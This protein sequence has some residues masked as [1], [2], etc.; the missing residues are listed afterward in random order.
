MSTNPILIDIPAE[1][2]TDRLRLRTPLPGDGPT[3][4]EAVCASHQ[5]LAPWM[6][7]A[8]SL[9]SL[10]ESEAFVRSQHAKF[11][12]RT[13]LQL[14]VF[15]RKSG[16]LVGSS[17]M[18]RI[19]WELRSFEIGYWLRSGYTGRGYATETVRAIAEFALTQ[20]QAHRVEIRVDERNT[21]SLAVAER[22]GF[23][24][25]GVLRNAALDAHG[26]P[27]NQVLFSRVPS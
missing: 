21:A 14:L 24:R 20:L 8:K 10:E 1:L 23:T 26:K 15:E 22:C 17:G 12:A 6:V 25:E 7:W 3:L 4:N 19:D 11:L 16:V 2:L 27:E 9:P 18:Q 13:D 5:E